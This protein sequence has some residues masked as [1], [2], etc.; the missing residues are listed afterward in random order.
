MVEI[1]HAYIVPALTNLV[2]VMEVETTDRLGNKLD[3][4]IFGCGSTIYLSFL[5]SIS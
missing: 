3:S 2:D 5:C 1:G 4:S